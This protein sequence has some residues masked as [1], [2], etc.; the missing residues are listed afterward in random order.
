MERKINPWDGSLSAS[1][2]TAETSTWFDNN[3]ISWTPGIANVFDWLAPSIDSYF[4]DQNELLP[5][6]WHIRFDYSDAGVWVNSATALINLQ[7]W[8]WTSYWVD[9]SWTD[10]I[11][12]DINNSRSIYILDDLDSWRYRTQFSISDNAW[13]TINEEIVF[14]IDN[15][16]MKITWWDINIWDITPSVKQF[17]SWEITITVNTI[18][19]WFNISQ[20]KSGLFSQWIN[21][22]WDY[23]WNYGFGYDLYKNENSSITNYTTDINII[24]GSNI[25]N[26][27]KNIDVNGVL[28]TYTYKVKLWVKTD[29]MQEPWKYSTILEYNLINS[30]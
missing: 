1:W 28:K 3:T 11:S 12:D 27:T 5:I 14:Y 24:N 9:T 6:A 18:W 25:S 22:I 30:Y 2:Y 17:S 8:N 7:K 21:N 10:I 20:N 29:S 19:A 23:D 4:P 13:N 26:I 16:S 15:F